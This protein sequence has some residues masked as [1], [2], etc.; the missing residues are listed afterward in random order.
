[1]EKR[2][3]GRKR[4]DKLEGCRKREQTIKNIPFL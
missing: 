3:R 2:T 1:L 4:K